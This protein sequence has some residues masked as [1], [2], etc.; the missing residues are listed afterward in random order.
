MYVYIIIENGNAYANAYISYEL[1]AA[2][3]KE[4]YAS[5]EPDDASE[6]DLPEHSSGTT[7][8]YVEK[9]INIQ[10]IRLAILVL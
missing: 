9:G 2:I 5:L 4:K 6:L 7:R 8:L 3:V 1:A 10:I